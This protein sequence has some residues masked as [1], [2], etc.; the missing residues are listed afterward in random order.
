MRELTLDEAIHK[1]KI[2]VDEKGT[3]AAG[4]TSFFTWRMNWNEDDEPVTFKCD[5]PFLFFLYHKIMNTVLFV[6]VY[7]SP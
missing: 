1:A 7:R 4:A 3:Q 2:K 5:R 6:G